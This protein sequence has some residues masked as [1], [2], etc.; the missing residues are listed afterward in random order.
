MKIKKLIAFCLA[1]AAMVCLVGCSGLQI[2]EVSVAEIPEMKEGDTYELTALFITDKED[3]AAEDI[4]KAVDKLG[5]AWTVEDET[6]ATVDENG[7]LTAVAAGE[8]KVSVTAGEFTASTE[9][10]VTEPVTDFEVIDRLA[11]SMDDEGVP[12]VVTLVPENAKADKVEMTSSDEA[13]VKVEGDKLV[14][15][16]VGEAEIKVVVDGIEKVIKV[17]VVETEEEKEVVTQS[18][19]K[20]ETSTGSTQGTNNSGSAST[21]GSNTSGGNN[22]TST[23]SGSTSG[24]NTSGGTTQTNPDPTPQPAPQPQPDPQPDQGNVNNGP[25]DKNEVFVVPPQDSNEYDGGNAVIGK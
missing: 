24:G 11:L 1:V 21:G 25:I 20:T 15:Q 17:E 5:V 18:Y 6:V 2:T 22:N 7:V 4:Q 14:P 16:G 13:I 19:T 23:G 10:V 9:V 12:V 8:T 3:A